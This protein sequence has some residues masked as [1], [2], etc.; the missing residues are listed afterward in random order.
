MIPTTTDMPP[1]FTADKSR[2]PT[3]QS[4]SPYP[5]SMQRLSITQS[6][7]GH[8]PIVYLATF[9]VRSPER[10]P[11]VDMYPVQTDPK[12]V[13]KRHRL[14]T[15]LVKCCVAQALEELGIHEGVCKT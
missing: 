14:L 7:D 3:K 15:L 11:N 13:P 4:I 2:P 9:R 8:Q 1:P 10:G 12:I 5:I 6:F